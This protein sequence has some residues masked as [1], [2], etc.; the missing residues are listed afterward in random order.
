MASSARRGVQM[1]LET[2]RSL[3]SS[4]IQISYGARRCCRQ[5]QC[6]TQSSLSLRD[7]PLPRLG[8]GAFR[9]A[10]EAVYKDKTGEALPYRQFGKPHAATY[11]FAEKMLRRHLTSLG[12]N[13]QAPLSVSVQLSRTARFEL[14]VCV[15]YMVGDNPESGLFIRSWPNII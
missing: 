14:T 3:L 8:M 13:P 4:R 1:Q 12:D 10:L 15:R 5:T 11:A 7:Y 9:I 6:A 2:R